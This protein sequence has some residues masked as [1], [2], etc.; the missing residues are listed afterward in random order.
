VC[1]EVDHAVSSGYRSLPA[2]ALMCT[3]LSHNKREMLSSGQIKYL[4]SLRMKKFRDLHGVFVAEGE[5]IVGELLQGG[6]H[7]EMLC[8]LPEWLERWQGQIPESTTC[9]PVNQK[10]LKRISS[11]KSPNQVLAVVSKPSAQVPD[12]FGTDELI[13]LL[14]RIQDP[15]NLGSIIRTAD[16]FD[17]RH[18][19]CSPG[20][21]DV[22]NPKVIQSTMGSFMRTKVSYTDLP[23]FIHRHRDR[24][25]FYG[26]FLDGQ[27]V[28]AS[29][30]RFPAAIVSGNESQG[31]SE[32]VAALLD[33]RLSIPA[34]PVAD[35]AGA[36][37][38]NAGIATGIMMACFNHRRKR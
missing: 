23:G 1:I 28:F 30:L 2:N 9:L 6:M 14:D 8:A 17:I 21:A 20:T 32:E 15:G 16:W 19:I 11:S 10:M 12:T 38:L 33:E 4:Q 24:I 13:L 5:K 18:I 34:G 7:A 36:E 29:T 35:R 25:R 22:Y 27:D 26:S 3:V 37:S 31:I